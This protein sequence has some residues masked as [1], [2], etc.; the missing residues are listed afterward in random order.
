VRYRRRACTTRRRGGEEG[1]TFIE[2]LIVIAIIL[3][4]TGTVGFIAFR[5]VD[6]AKEVAARSQ[7]DTFTLAL[8]AYLFDNGGYPSQTQGLDALW[9]KPTA[10]T[11]PA[12]WKGTYIE[13]KVPLDPWGH[14]YQY[15]VPGPNGL[16]FGIRSF[17]SD[18][19]E[20][21]SGNAADITS[22]ER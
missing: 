14:P 3:I 10:G 21:G 20:G 18:G 8:N 11:E 16:P 7:I 13:R 19:A 4:L 12:N 15:Q 9:Q 5:Y 17:G 22:W 6:S 2:T 1:W